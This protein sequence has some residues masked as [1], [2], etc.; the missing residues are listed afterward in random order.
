[1]ERRDPITNV[2]IDDGDVPVYLPGTP[3]LSFVRTIERVI[4]M[5]RR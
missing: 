2:P 3:T 4:D 5:V 1:M